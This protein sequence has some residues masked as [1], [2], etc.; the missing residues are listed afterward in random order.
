MTHLAALRVLQL[1]AGA[2][3]LPRAVRAALLGVT[4]LLLQDVLRGDVHPGG[5]VVVN[6]I[7]E[8]DIHN[9]H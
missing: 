6:V 3:V 9:C 7:L 8:L 4:F 1:A 2:E 5:R